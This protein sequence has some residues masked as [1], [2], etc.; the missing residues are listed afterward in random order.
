MG[1]Y[2]RR[3]DTACMSRLL[4][5]SGQLGHVLKGS[6]LARKANELI[7]LTRR[8]IVT[9]PSWRGMLQRCPSYPDDDNDNLLSNII[10]K[11]HQVIKVKSMVR[12]H[13]REVELMTC[14]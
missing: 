6:C 4:K 7:G 1:P 12:G 3:R 2:G 10:D 8:H 9:W 14:F 5:M 11:L 13:V